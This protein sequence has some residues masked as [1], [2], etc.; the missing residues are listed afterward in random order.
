MNR[1][2]VAS[3]DYYMQI[4]I[5]ICI[6]LALFSAIFEKEALLVAALGWFFFGLWQVFMSIVQAIAFKDQHRIKHLKF[7]LLYIVGGIATGFFFETVNL[8]GL[9]QLYSFTALIASV[10]LA[11][12]CFSLS[13]KAKDAE[14]ISYL[15]DF[16]HEDL[17]DENMIYD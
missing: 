3:F 10:V 12:W 2:S 4:F 1:K 13:R 16:N 7:S 17:L 8:G 5:A 6:G 11:I 9:V 14:E 15:K